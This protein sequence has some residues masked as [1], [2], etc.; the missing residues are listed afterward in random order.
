MSPP[1]PITP[2]AG[3][4]PDGADEGAAADG[5]RR[6]PEPGSTEPG[7]TEPG[8][9]EPGSP[10]PFLAFEARRARLRDLLEAHPGCP[11]AAYDRAIAFVDPGPVLDRLAVPADGHPAVGG[12]SILEH[13]VA[14]D[15]LEL[16][17]AFSTAL[18][19]GASTLDVELRVGGRAR[20]TY[21]DFHPELGAAVLVVVL[22]EGVALPATPLASTTEHSSRL[23]VMHRTRAAVISRVDGRLVS[24]LGWSSG[25]LVGHG[26]LEFVHPDD[27][28]QGVTNWLD[29]LSNPCTTA[30]WR[31]RYRRRDGSWLWV[32][33]SSVYDETTD[34]VRT[35]L[36]DV[37]Q[38]VEVQQRLAAR[39]ELLSALAETLPVGVACVD[40]DG[41]IAYAN[42]RLGLLLGTDVRGVADLTRTTVGDKSL[43]RAIEALLRAGRPGRLVARSTADRTTRHLEW[44]LR[45][46]H[47]ADGARAG[48]VICVADVT[49]AVELRAR[50]ERQASTD[51]LT[52]CLNRAATLE[53]VADALGRVPA[54]RGVAVMFVDLNH[55]K[56]I[57]DNHG[58]AAGDA[59]LAAVA[60]RLRGALR[61]GDVVGRVGGDEFVVVSPDL[62]D[63]EAARR[64]AERISHRLGNDV[65]LTGGTTVTVS[66]S[67]GVAW[68]AGGSPDELVAAADHAMYRAK[69][70]ASL[71]P[72]V[73]D[74]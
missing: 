71:E 3:G 19:R 33:A 58:H 36:L 44:T 62:E 10:E 37:H 29:T 34:E 66:A 53:A 65:A 54:G 47:G 12:R 25:E 70:A 45:A 30:R 73:A 50:L 8:S 23:G 24:L 61:P 64:A 6:S 39:E 31:C 26:S 51:A 11:I 72:V 55:F 43:A 59:V 32:E 46:R 74:L 14:A 68:A 41:T 28:E 1:S 60:G 16:G 49:E 63:R 56:E 4:L 57:N 21:V 13:I 7:S 5:G 15:A 38:E 69:R 40:P 17:A 52:R 9:P 48:G 22:S 67:I 18:E 27:H 42:D 2:I 35:E 20:L